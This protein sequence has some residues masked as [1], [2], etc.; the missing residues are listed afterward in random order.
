[1][2]PV[3]SHLYTWA[4]VIPSAW[5]SLPLP[6]DQLLLL[7]FKIAVPPESPFQPG[8]NLCGHSYLFFAHKGCNYAGPAWGEGRAGVDYVTCESCAASSRHLLA[9]PSVVPKRAKVSGMC[10]ILAHRDVYCQGCHPEDPGVGLDCI[11]SSPYVEDLN[12]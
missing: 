8:H 7:Y 12:I 5:K 11:Q 10:D 1:M 4:N 2:H 3:F 6:L 9:S